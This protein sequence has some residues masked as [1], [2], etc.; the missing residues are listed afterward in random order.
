MVSITRKSMVLV[1]AVLNYFPISLISSY[2]NLLPYIDSYYHANRDNI[3]ISVDPLWVISVWICTFIFGMIFTSPIER[4]V[5]IHCSIITGD[6]LV[7]IC[8]L[9]GYFAVKEPLTFTVVFGGV[10]GVFAGVVYSLIV[11]LLL[12]TM[13]DHGGLASGIMAAGPVLGAMLFLGVAYIVVNP[14]NEKPDLK[15][16]KKVFFSNRNLISRVPYYFLVM[17]S[18]TASFTLIGAAFMYYGSWK[19]IQEKEEEEGEEETIVT[20]NVTSRGELHSHTS[21][22]DSGKCEV[23]PLNVTGNGAQ[24]QERIPGRL[25]SFFCPKSSPKSEVKN[26]VSSR[27]IRSTKKPHAG[28]DASPW[29]AMKTLRFWLVWLAYITSNHTNFLHLNLYKQYGQRIIRDDKLFVTAGIISNAGL[30]IVQPL[31]GAASDRIG[32]RSTNVYLNAASCLFMCLMVVSLHTFPWVYMV[33]VVVENL[34][35]SPHTLL[36]S[37]LGAYEFGKTHCASNMGLI[38][39]GNLVLVLLEPLFVDAMVKAIGWDWLY[40]TG[41]LA[42]AV[43]TLAIIALDWC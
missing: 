27:K 18:I 29:E 33:L 43:A 31:V 8:V 17:G 23:V 12:Q 38:R 4:R 41:G 21:S 22:T 14:H 32:I 11:K 35:V 15:F 9:G 19:L 13:P 1:G 16:D 30:V 2:G 10:Q 42:S 25:R 5:G 24:E 7:S 34:G 39:S 6:I 3:H 36:F 26:S 37:L 28:V 20:S 40:I